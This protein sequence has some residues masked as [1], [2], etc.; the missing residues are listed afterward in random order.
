MLKHFTELFLSLPYG[1]KKKVIHAH[2]LM[3]TQTIVEV[4]SITLFYNLISWLLTGKKNL[5]FLDF[6]P[7]NSTALFYQY[8]V[9]LTVVTIIL[10]IVV[11]VVAIKTYSIVASQVGIEIGNLIFNKILKSDF[12][13]LQKHSPETLKKEVALESMRASNLV[14]LPLFRLISKGILL[15]GYFLTLCQISLVLSV[16]SL[17][18]GT[19]VYLCVFIFIQK[20]LRHNDGVIQKSLENRFQVLGDGVGASRTIKMF[21]LDEELLTKFRILGRKYSDSFGSNQAAS[22][23]PKYF[24]EGIIFITVIIGFLAFDIPKLKGESAAVLLTFGAVFMKAL[25]SAQQVFRSL[26][27]MRGNA[28]ALSSVVSSMQGLPSAIDRNTGTIAASINKELVKLVFKNINF[29]IKEGLCLSNLC[30]EVDSKKPVYLTGPSGSGKT[31]LFDLVSSLLVPD[32]GEAIALLGTQEIRLNQYTVSYAPQEHYMFDR[33]LEHN[34]HLKNSDAEVDVWRLKKAIVIFGLAEVFRKRASE[35]SRLLSGGE[36]QRIILARA[37]YKRSYILLFD[38]PFSALDKATEELITRRLL[39]HLEGRLLMVI[40]H[41]EILADSF[42][43]M[44][45]SHGKLSISKNSEVK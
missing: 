16:L 3:V 20:A 17:I 28:S 37:W 38:E 6:L 18:L 7:L 42:T 1:T 8:H 22:E 5:S 44:S 31:T 34:I 32:S 25:P 13:E 40:T 14:F 29:K 45:L 41:S 15:V 4:L 36:K 23:Y 43:Q 24:I 39:R 21:N 26:A 35:K 10:S 11:S 33:G 12:I 19:L 2:I 9:L 30:F 27:V